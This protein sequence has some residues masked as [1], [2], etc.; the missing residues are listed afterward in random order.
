MDGLVVA[1][2]VVPSSKHSKINMIFP[3]KSLINLNYF[4]TL[5][6]CTEE[7]FVKINLNVAQVIFFPPELCNLMN[8]RFLNYLSFQK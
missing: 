7:A 5:G 8:E 2:G 6:L 3:R 1:R 4:Y